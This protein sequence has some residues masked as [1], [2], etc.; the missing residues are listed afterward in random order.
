GTEGEPVLH[1]DQGTFDYQLQPAFEGLRAEN[2]SLAKRDTV[3]SGTLQVHDPRDDSKKPYAG[4]PLTVELGGATTTVAADAAGRFASKLTLA[5]D[6]PVYENG[7]QSGSP[8]VPVSLTASLNGI[9]KSESARATVNAVGARITLD[10]NTQTGA[11]GTRAKV[12][13]AVTWKSP[14]GTYKPAPAGLK[15][16]TGPASATTDGSGRFTGSPQFLDDAP[17]TVVENSPWLDGSGPQVTVNTTAGSRFSVF[18]AS[19]DEKK[20]VT[21][22]ARF[23]RAEIPAG[24]TSLT[25]E[26]QHSA[27]G[28]T[29]W[30]TH[31][32]LNVAT[33]PGTNTTASIDTTV[34]YPGPGY[35]RLRHASTTAVHG[36]VTPAV[37]VARTITAITEFNASPEPVKKGKPLTVTGKLNRAD[38]AWKPLSNATVHYYFRPAGSTTWKVMGHSVTATD[39]TFTKTFTAGATGSWTARYALTDLYH[40]ASNS[41]A[42]GVIVN[43]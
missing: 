35:I 5:G 11:Y 33:K 15:I 24:T 4:G 41:R 19:V 37:K 36:S 39:G 8:Y 30:T 6:E 16:S 38:T 29:G 23:D 31:K 42:D 9:K 21:V 14:D 10:A 2:V 40:F 12:S 17:W 27:D 18:A 20:T 34:P 32:S 28:K 3:V 7:G 26:V 25:V 22:K 1:K 43:P 13:G